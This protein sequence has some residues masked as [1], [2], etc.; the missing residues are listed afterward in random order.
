MD[1]Q[2]TLQS[3]LAHITAPLERE[4]VRWTLIGSA[5]T[6]L[7]G[8]AI[9]PNDLDFLTQTPA[10]TYR[11]AELLAAEMPATCPDPEGELGWYSSQAEPLR[12]GPDAYSYTWTFARWYLD[13]CKVEA[14]HI[15]PPAHVHAQH[16]IWEAGPEIWPYVRA[17]RWQGYPVPV[18]PLE[19]QLGTS[20]QRRLTK[21]VGAIVQVLGAQGFDEPLLRQCLSPAQWKRIVP[22]LKQPT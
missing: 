12:I 17:V 5:A 14:A 7:Q 6:A 20:L 21:R 19:I 2:Q 4:Q 1:W 18:V 22:R 11:F 15:M 13:G 8:C 16:G 10:G 3:V 9:Q